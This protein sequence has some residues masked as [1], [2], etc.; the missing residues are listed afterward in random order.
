MRLQVGSVCMWFSLTYLATCLSNRSTGNPETVLKTTP[1]ADV[2]PGY[3]YA[4]K[5][6]IIIIQKRKIKLYCKHKNTIT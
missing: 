2:F 3:N 5:T 4:R 6:I 1:S